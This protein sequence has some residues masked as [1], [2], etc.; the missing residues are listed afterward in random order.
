MNRNTFYILT[1]EL[2]KAWPPELHSNE[3]AGLEI[4]KMAGSL[5]VM[6]TGKDRATEGV[7]GGNIDMTFISED[8]VIVLPV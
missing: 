5:M 1:H 6:V 2:C 4:S 7:F 3:L 8:M